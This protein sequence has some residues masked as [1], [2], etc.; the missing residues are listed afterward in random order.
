MGTRFL[1]RKSMSIY[2]VSI[3]EGAG[4]LDSFFVGPGVSESFWRRG[5]LVEGERNKERKRVNM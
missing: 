1:A 3:Y 4:F 2:E 5:R